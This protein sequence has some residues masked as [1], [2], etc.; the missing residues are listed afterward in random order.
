MAARQLRHV[1][2]RLEANGTLPVALIVSGNAAMLRADVLLECARLPE[3]LVARLAL[4]RLLAPVHRADVHLEVARRPERLA[5]RLALVRLL[6][7]VDRADVPLE[8][9]RL[10]ERLAAR[11]ARMVFLARVDRPARNAIRIGARALRTAAGRS[12]GRRHFARG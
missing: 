10:P 11:L 12:R 7:P 9:A 3:R 5:A 6:A 4:V 1:G 8:V 2:V